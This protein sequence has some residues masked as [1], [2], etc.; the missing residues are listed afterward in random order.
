[1]FFQ[2]KVDIN[3]RESM[4]HFLEGHYRY[5]TMNSWNGTRSYANCVKIHSLGI[6][7]NLVNNAYE[8]VFLDEVNELISDNIDLFTEEHD[9]NYT[10]GLNGRSSG[11]LVLYRSYYEDTGYA[12]RCSCCGQL[13][14][15]R[16]WDGAKEGPEGAL[17]KLLFSRPGLF[18]SAYLADPTFIA[19]DLPLEEKVALLKSLEGRCAKATWS[20][21]CGKCGAEGEA[22]RKNL[23]G[24]LRRL[25]VSS[26]SIDEDVD[27]DE[28]S[29]DNLR[30]KV[31]LI[32]S[33]DEVCDSIREQFIELLEGTELVEETV[34]VP[35]TVRRLVSKEEVPA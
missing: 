29:T 20:N 35:K 27:F 25:R 23:N 7:A 24:P 19:V 1:M 14:Y 13:N 5:N 3:S 2:K 17:A 33:F 8:S 32:S 4:I 15:K 22:G 18:H 30:E 9:G 6:P 11:Y 10:I 28:L 16:V 34:L 26:Q 21:K 31:E 12:S